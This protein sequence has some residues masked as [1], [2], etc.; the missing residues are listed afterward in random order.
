[1][2]YALQVAYM[3]MVQARNE[4]GKVQFFVL[5]KLAEIL[6]PV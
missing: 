2:V 1:M 6:F 3:L 5:I 4:H